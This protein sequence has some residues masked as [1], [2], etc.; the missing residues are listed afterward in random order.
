M[1]QGLTAFTPSRLFIY[2]NER[3]MEGTVS[4][5]AGASIRD[6]IKSV[7]SIGAPPESD[8]PYDIS[9]FTVAPPQSAYDAAKLD[10][11]V[12]YL[13][14][15]QTLDAM[16]QCLADGYPIVGGFTVYQ[17]FDAADLMPA[18]VPMPGPNES[19]LGGHCILIVGYDD[20]RQM[21][22]IRNSWGV[23]WGDKGYGYMPYAYLTDPDLADDFWAIE[24]VGTAP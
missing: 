11:A 1:K 20:A 6:G 12:K 14:V 18:I 3:V 16:K 2:Y 7:A 8:W 13:S 17:S 21:F 10:C 22:T 24:L 9:Q 19:V 15:D 4:S 23:G 5:D